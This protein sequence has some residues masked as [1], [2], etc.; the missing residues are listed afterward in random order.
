MAN[1]KIKVI[2]T[3]DGKQYIQELDKT[4]KKTTRFSDK[5]ESLS[6]RMSHMTG[7]IKA[8]AA[9]F[10][11]WKLAAAI[12]STITMASSINDLSTRIGASVEALSEYRHVA[13]LTK[14][15]FDTLTT[16]WQRQ[17]RRI[18]EAAQGTGEA[19]DALKELGL[20][21]TDLA[22]LAPEDQFEIIADAMNGVANQGDKVRLAMK[23]WDTEGVAL[24]QTVEGGSE[25]LR[26]MREE[27]RK[28]GLSLSREQADGA[29]AAKDAIAR[30][31][32]AMS[33]ITQE[34]GLNVIPAFTEIVKWIGKNLPG[35]VK[36]AKESLFFLLGF[37]S[38]FAGQTIRKFASISG[39][40]GDFLGIDALK[41]ARDGLNSVAVSLQ[42]VS[43]DYAKLAI[44]VFNV[45]KSTFQFKTESQKAADV[46]HRN[47]SP[48]IENVAN[49]EADLAKNT[50]AA[51]KEITEQA[52]AIDGTVSAALDLSNAIA[53]VTATQAKQAA[54]PSA[55][56]S[57]GSSGGTTPGGAGT[58]TTVTTY[59]DRPA[60]GQSHFQWTKVKEQALAKFLGPDAS[61]A[62]IRRAQTRP[63]QEFLRFAIGLNKQLGFAHGGSFTVGGTGGTDSQA[64]GFRATPGERVTV[65][66]P[67]QQSGAAIHIGQ[68]VMNG[69]NDVSAFVRELERYSRG[70]PINMQLGNRATVGG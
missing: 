36:A 43:D 66:T 63:S 7:L 35:A 14:V 37:I 17:T 32:S 25:A 53:K 70:T 46:M 60:T 22:K 38:D 49:K 29:A 33:G 20:S 56:A 51:T 40:V 21:A 41:N 65:Q 10:G 68:V 27:S 9:G 57:S 13:K 64:V 28:L 34:I 50:D 19:K 58:T 30:L 61:G 3:A 69:V 54:A 8:A 1:K 62:A 52:A 23:L 45:E 16:A 5:T 39:A 26:E 42:N 24:L 15:T 31:E 4:G 59:H 55:P 12:N 67:D 47:L 18:S 11:A 44:S 2:I 48:A 6:A